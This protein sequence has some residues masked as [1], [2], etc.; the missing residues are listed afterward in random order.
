MK[1]LYSFNLST[2]RFSFAV[3][4]MLLLNAGLYAATTVSFTNNTVAAIPDAAYNGSLGSMAGTQV[5]VSGI[6]AGA[7]I[8]E[9][10]LIAAVNHTWVGDVVLKLESPDLTVLGLMSRP[11][12]A[13]AN[14]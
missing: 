4:L 10:R 11:G 14:D 1:N 8:K 5:I 9:I 7:V 6:P 2:G 12:F 13:E 3:L